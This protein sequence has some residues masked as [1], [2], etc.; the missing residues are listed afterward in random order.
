MGKKETNITSDKLSKEKNVDIGEIG[1]GGGIDK[2]AES[3]F[4]ELAEES[5]FMNQEVL[6][7]VHE[8]ADKQVYDFVVPSVNG[9]TQPIFRG[10]KSVVKRKYVEALARARYTSY[11]QITPDPSKPANILMKARTVICDPFTVL[12]DENPVG[13]EWLESI[14]KAA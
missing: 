1:K 14:A 9:I 13:K 10:V 5:A 8:N 2:V 11:E 12:K 6:I 4:F 7:I 3:K